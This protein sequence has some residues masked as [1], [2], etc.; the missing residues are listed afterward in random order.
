MRDAKIVTLYKTKGERSDCNNYRGISLL[1]IIGKVYARVLL[2]RLQK[3]ALRKVGCPPKLHSLLESFHSNMKGTVQFNGNISE[4]FNI[5]SGIK[6][7]CVLALTLFGIFFALLLRHAF[8]TAQEGIY[9]RTR[10][11]GRFFNLAHLKA[12]TKVRETLIRDMLF[13]D[14]AAVAT[15]TQRELQLLI[16]RFSQACKDFALTISLKKTNVLGQDTPAPPV[17]TIDDY[18]LDVVHQFTYLGSTITDN[19]SLDAEIDKRIGK[20]A[21]TLARFTS[22]VW[23]NP[24]LTVKTKMTVYNAWV[25]STLLYWQRDMNHICPPEEKAQFIPFQK[26]STHT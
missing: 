22:R 2:I 15:H 18:E 17:I 4:P 16:D 8:G 20:A 23:T 26:P 12:R 1:G 25:L 9:L 3:L 10:S 19:L 13:A 6:Q 11:D 24:K 14:D 21:T 5:R 7:G